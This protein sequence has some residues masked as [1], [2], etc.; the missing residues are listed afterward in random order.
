MVR[1]QLVLAIMYEVLIVTLLVSL[2]LILIVIIYDI[3]V[4]IYDIRVIKMSMCD[5]PKRIIYNDSMLHARRA[6]RR[7]WQMPDSY[8]MT[9]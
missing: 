3:R 6:W 7:A 9:D 5:K 2:N 1:L 8:G 4:I